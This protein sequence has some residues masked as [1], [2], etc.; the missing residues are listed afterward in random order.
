MSY[1]SSDLSAATLA[2]MAVVMIASLAAWLTLVFLAA[3]EPR[4]TEGRARAGTPGQ[5]PFAGTRN[6]APDATTAGSGK[7]HASDHQ[8]AA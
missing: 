1:P 8:V 5:A 6:A 3:R 4:D 7:N 2:I